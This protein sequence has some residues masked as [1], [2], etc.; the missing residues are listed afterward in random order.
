MEIDREDVRTDA[1]RDERKRWTKVSDDPESY[2]LGRTAGLSRDGDE[3]RLFLIAGPRHMREIARHPVQGDDPPFLWARREHD[4]VQERRRTA[5][6]EEKTIGKRKPGEEGV[7][8]GR[9]IKGQTTSKGD[10]LRVR[11]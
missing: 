8:G 5:R 10:E 7:N 2:S 6:W 3:W 4:V 1:Y 9:L 11:G